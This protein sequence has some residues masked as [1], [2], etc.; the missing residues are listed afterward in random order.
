MDRFEASGVDVGNHYSNISYI[1]A[2]FDGY[3]S[4][5][6]TTN[7]FWEPCILVV[8]FNKAMSYLFFLLITSVKKMLPCIRE[9]VLYFYCLIIPCVNLLPWLAGNCQPFTG[10]YGIIMDIRRVIFQQT[11][12][13]HVNL[14]ENRMPAPFHPLDSYN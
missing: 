11:G 10:N 2:R 12:S 1:S 4:P 14:S 9:Y 6:Q 3:T 13:D 7:E 5:Y 8:L